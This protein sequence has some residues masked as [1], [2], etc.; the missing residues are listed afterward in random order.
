[1]S[2]IWSA[3]YKATI[4]D[5]LQTAND[6]NEYLGDKLT[7]A[8]ARAVVA[9]ADAER[10]AE[11]LAEMLEAWDDYEMLAALASETQNKARVA[12]AAHDAAKGANHA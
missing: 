9:E 11:P 12:L 10:L 5:E 2:D 4:L 7:A 3:E 1:M 8:T 6:A